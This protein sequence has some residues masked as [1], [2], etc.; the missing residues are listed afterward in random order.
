MSYLLIVLLIGFLIFVHELGHFLAAKVSGIPIARFSIGFGPKVCVFTMGDTEYCISVVPLGGYV[1]PAIEDS[2]EF[3]QIPWKKRMLFALAGPAANVLFAALGIT[4]LNVMAQGIS[5]QS[6][7]IEPTIKTASSFHLFI[8]SIPMIFEQ[9]QNLSGIVGI[10]SQGSQ[11]VGFSLSRLLQFSVMLNMNLAVFN[12]LP[13]PP[14]DGGNIVLYILEKIH[15][16]FLKLHMPL[17]VSGWILLLGLMLYATVLDIS[18][19]SSG[20]HG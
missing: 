6:V 12:L 1:M 7:F 3:F 9:H 17:A 2:T 8:C 13:F 5:F 14:L 16:K 18:R 15:P 20:I 19:I 4:L 11:Y 10:V